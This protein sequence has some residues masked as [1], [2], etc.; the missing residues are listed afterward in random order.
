M[1]T[2]LY[3]SPWKHFEYA[4]RNHKIEF[5][6]LHRETKIG[7]NELMIKNRVQ[8]RFLESNTSSGY[9]SSR[10]THYPTFAMFG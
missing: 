8:C 7:Y 9:P 2:L 10:I 4:Y 5:D 1:S 6:D 3:L